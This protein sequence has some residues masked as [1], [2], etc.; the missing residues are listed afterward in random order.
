[1]SISLPPLPGRDQA[2]FRADHWCRDWTRTVLVLWKSSR[3]WNYHLRTEGC[4][5]RLSKTQCKV[6]FVRS[7]EEDL[8]RRD[9]TVNALCL[10]WRRGNYW[11]LMDWKIWRTEFARCWCSDGTLFNEDASFWIM[12]GFRFPQV[13]LGFDLEEAT[14]HYRDRMCSHLRKFLFVERVFIELDKLLLAP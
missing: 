6:N 1:M 4:S 7:L 5:R 9:F 2:L 11:P 10:E 14:L 8:K 3:L 13:S 12:R